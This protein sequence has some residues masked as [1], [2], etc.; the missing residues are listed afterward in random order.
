MTVLVRMVAAAT[1]LAT[2]AT[3]AVAADRGSK[4]EAK[5][6]LDKAIAH[7]DAVGKDKAFADFSR[8]DGGFVDRD[9][10]VFCSDMKGINLA[11]G[12]NPA[13][14]GENMMNLMDADGVHVLHEM[15]HVVQTSGEGWVDYKWPNAV[16]KKIEPKSSYV[17]K[18]ADDW[19]GVGYYKS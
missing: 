4:E 9:L 1:L 14:V 11:H 3:F 15:I 17:R 8:H 6:L 16:T 2:S 18:T 10:Y 7:V 12:S 13:L 19:C 5:A